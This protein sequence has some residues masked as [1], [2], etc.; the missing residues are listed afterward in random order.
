MNSKMN[1]TKPYTFSASS[2]GEENVR[3]YDFVNVETSVLDAAS[4]E[5]VRDLL[6]KRLGGL[7]FRRVKFI[8]LGKNGQGR[9]AHRLH[10]PDGSRLISNQEA[11]SMVWEDFFARVTTKINGPYSFETSTDPAF[12]AHDKFK[13]ASIFGTSS[14][15]CELDPVTLCF[16]P[17]KGGDAPRVSHQTHGSGL[18]GGVS[19]DQDDPASLVVGE[20]V[21]DRKTGRLVYSR[22]CLASIQ[23]INAILLCL[24]PTVEPPSSKGVNKGFSKP[25]EVSRA[26]WLGGQRLRTNVYRATEFAERHDGTPL[27]PE[28]KQKHFRVHQG[29][30]FEEFCHVWA[31]WVLMAKYGE[32]PHNNNIPTTIPP[33]RPKDPSKLASYYAP[34][35]MK[36]WDL[37]RVKLDGR[38]KLMKIDKYIINLLGLVFS[39]ETKTVPI[40]RL[41][42]VPLDFVDEVNEDQSPS[43]VPSRSSSPVNTQD[44][45]KLS[46]DSD[47]GDD[48]TGIV[49]EPP[50]LVFAWGDRADDSEEMDFDVPVSDA[51]SSTQDTF[52]AQGGWL[53]YLASLV[54][55]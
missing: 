15:R 38:K 41:A 40:N 47:D 28:A 11:N 22:W 5:K 50:T 20:V 4:V 2:K 17:A 8:N 25:A 16:T 23:T 19:P 7:V 37:P 12:P 32:V 34:K 3:G 9:T 36:H 21:R 48:A 26:F 51:I 24:D 35:A 33:P 13:G 18:G 31:M 30:R 54:K 49:E 1:P 52:K 45:E 29:P 27:S 6:R 46:Q 44:Y 42:L 10:G 53:S 43:L 55:G 14:A 39:T